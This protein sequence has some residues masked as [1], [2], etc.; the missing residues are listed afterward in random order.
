MRGILISIWYTHIYGNARNTST[1]FQLQTGESLRAKK[2]KEMEIDFQPITNELFFISQEE[3]VRL[4]S[5]LDWDYP[6]QKVKI[7]DYTL[8]ACPFEL[9][10][11]GFPT[12]IVFEMKEGEIILVGTEWKN[13]SQEGLDTKSN[14]IGG[15][16]IGHP[17]VEI[18]R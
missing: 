2:D 7:E 13:R 15:I 4:T 18:L 3:S 12:Q 8:G 1:Y 14:L 17:I 6:G 9:N 11:R 10:I 16:H 5:Q